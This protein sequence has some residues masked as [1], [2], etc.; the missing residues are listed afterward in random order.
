[1]LSNN[2]SVILQGVEESLKKLINVIALSHTHQHLK[3]SKPVTLILMTDEA[4]LLINK[5]VLN[6]DYY[7]DVITFDYT[8]DGDVNE[9]EI[10]ISI[11]RV[12]ENARLNSTSIQNELQRIAIHGL[13]HLSGYNDSTVEERNKMTGQENRFLDLYCST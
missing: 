4:L 2:I 13:L 7:T 11:D 1:M 12:E 8:D 3:I 10:C 6:H 9:H 5:Q